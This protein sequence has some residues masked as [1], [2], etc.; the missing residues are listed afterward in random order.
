[1]GR[2]LVRSTAMR[3]ALV[4]LLGLLLG[5]AV[6]VGAGAALYSLL[7][8]GAVVV[9][10]AA[11]LTPPPPSPTPVPAT[12]VPTATPGASGSPGASVTPSAA[13]SPTPAPSSVFPL[14]GKQAPR[15]VAPQV[16]GGQIDLAELRGKP[17]WVVF[18]GTYCP[19]CRD[20]YPLMNG[21]AARYAAAGLIVIGIHVKEDAAAV[22][23]FADS[24][25]VIFPLGIDADG[26]R[27]AAWDAA[28]LPVHYFIDAQ[29]VVRDAALGGLGADQMA[30]AL[31]TIL[32]GG[33]VRP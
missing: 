5:V 32:P 22:A 6:A 9:S 4:I 19:P 18:T 26:S 33:D 25:N 16:G 1:M 15:L 17:V 31:G 21:F 2:S 29:G 14:V 10:S 30:R 23:L 11:P 12:P 3:S 24:L 28:A 20:E 13:G 8:A 7:P 27:A